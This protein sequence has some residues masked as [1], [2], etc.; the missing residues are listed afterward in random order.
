[1]VKI[2]QAAHMGKWESHTAMVRLARDL[3]ERLDEA[4]LLSPEDQT[5]VDNVV[6]S[7]LAD[8]PQKVRDEVLH[9]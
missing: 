4:G 3:A 9:G 1:M 7:F 8:L 2:G 5:S 6:Y